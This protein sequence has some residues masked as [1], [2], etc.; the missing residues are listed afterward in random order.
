VSP[1]YERDLAAATD[2]VERLLDGREPGGYD[3]ATAAEIVQ[4]MFG[5][6]WRPTQA[7]PAPGPS[8]PRAV[9]YG[10]PASARVFL[11]TLRRRAAGEPVAWAGS[12]TVVAP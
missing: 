2:G 12:V 9:E 1:G 3:R 11:E 7:R 8:G 4:W 10:P 5:H 6:G